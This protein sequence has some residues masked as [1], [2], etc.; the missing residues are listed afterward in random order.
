MVVELI[1][2]GAKEPLYSDCRRSGRDFKAFLGRL[3][4]LPIE[5]KP[6]VFIFHC[7]SES[8]DWLSLCLHCRALR[9]GRLGFRRLL[10]RGK[11]E[12]L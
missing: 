12:E 1:G 2:D 5:L 7:L 11:L 9:L 6:P 3:A 10:T 4:F 8:G